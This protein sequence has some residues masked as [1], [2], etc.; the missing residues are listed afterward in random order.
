MT[1][2]DDTPVTTVQPRG[3]ERLTQRHK[4]IMERYLSGETATVIAAALGVHQVTVSRVI[5]SPAFQMEAGHRRAQRT[6]NGD[7][8][9]ARGA[10]KARE[11]LDSAAVEAVDVLTGIMR[12]DE[13]SAATRM[14]SAK[15]VLDRVF[16]GEDVG[17][18][19]PRLVINTTNLSL[20]RTALLESAQP[21]K[22][23]PD[24]DVLD[25]AIVTE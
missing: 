6:A 8:E 19:G 2:C 20:I 3:V 23:L 10:S 25:A 16:A 1:T 4:E 21:L 7:D 14:N 24:G 9:A 11:L 17:A 18:G 15:I 12:S 5:N 22:E 13:A